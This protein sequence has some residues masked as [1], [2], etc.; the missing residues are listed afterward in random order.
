[1]FR[2]SNVCLVESKLSNTSKLEGSPGCHDGFHTCY[3]NGRNDRTYLPQTYTSLPWVGRNEVGLHLARIRV[4]SSS[5]QSATNHPCLVLARFICLRV[6]CW[7]VAVGPWTNVKK[8]K[9]AAGGRQQPITA[10]GPK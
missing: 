10:L 7:P 2:K 6:S 1:M 4:L 5:C 3:P 8:V 9:M